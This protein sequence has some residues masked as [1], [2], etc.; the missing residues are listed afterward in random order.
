MS[1]YQFVCNANII[2]Q[3]E[4]SIFKEFGKKTKYQYFYSNNEIYS[5]FGISNLDF[6]PIYIRVIVSYE[7]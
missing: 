7:L 1:Q 2:F 4:Q 3:T 5:K 6:F